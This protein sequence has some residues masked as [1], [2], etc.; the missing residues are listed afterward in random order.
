MPSA[1]RPFDSRSKEYRE[2]KNPPKKS[3]AGRHPGDPALKLSKLAVN[4]AAAE[5][6]EIARIALQKHQ[7]RA[8]DNSEALIWLCKNSL[9]L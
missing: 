1:I 7:G 8:V 2:M 4:N 3:T 6:F 9:D 5:M